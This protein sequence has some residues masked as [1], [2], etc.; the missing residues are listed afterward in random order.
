[1]LFV[2]THE[3]QVDEKGRLA[4]PAPFRAHLGET[5]YLAFGIDQCIDVVPVDQFENMAAQLMAQVERGE[6]SRSVQRV[7]SSSASLVRVDG[8]GRVNLDENLRRYAGLRPDQKVIVTGNFDRV[9]IWSPD[10][11]QRIQSAGTTELAGEP[12]GAAKATKT[13][14]T[15]GRKERGSTRQTPGARR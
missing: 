15:T 8:Q 7:V 5:C 1:M 11:H 3:R 9:E 6:V 2:G 13:A 12:A 14:S 4:L 10:V